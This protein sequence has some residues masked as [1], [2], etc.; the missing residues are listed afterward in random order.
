[1][2]EQR[3]ERGGGGGARVVAQLARRREAPG[4]QADRGAFDIAFDAGDLA[5]KAQPRP[6]SAASAP[7]SRR[8]ELMKVLRCRPPSRAKLAFS[9]PGMVRKMRV[10]SPCLSLVWKPTMF[11]SVPSA[12]SW[13]SCTTA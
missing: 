8:G 3:A 7:S 11:H 6:P 10:C 1:M 2:R 12:L 13:R 5:G 4:Q 9:S